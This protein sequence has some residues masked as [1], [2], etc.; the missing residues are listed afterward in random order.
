MNIMDKLTS[1]DLV[2]MQIVADFFEMFMLASTYG[3]G[4]AGRGPLIIWK[5]MVQGH[6]GPGPLIWKNILSQMCSRLEHYLNAHCSRSR[7]GGP[8]TIA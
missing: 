1:V 6:N 5:N 3:P 7:G 2:V 4:A 8:D